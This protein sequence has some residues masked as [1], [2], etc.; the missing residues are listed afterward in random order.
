M[1]VS[2]R[3]L[4]ARVPLDDLPAFHR[5]FLS[6]RGVAGAEEMPLRRVQQRVEAELNRWVQSGEAAREGEDLRVRRAAL[7]GFEA[8]RPWLDGAAPGAHPD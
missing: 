5:A 1:S 2:W 3:G 4:E 6:W 8:A 7:N